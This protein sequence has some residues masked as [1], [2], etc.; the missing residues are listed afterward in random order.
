[1][2]VLSLMRQS[3]KGQID[4]AIN[5]RRGEEENKVKPKSKS[6]MELAALAG[7]DLHRTYP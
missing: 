5:F 3:V 7:P 2:L 4:E 6:K 1:M